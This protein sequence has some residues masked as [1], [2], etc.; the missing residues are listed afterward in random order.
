MTEKVA[1]YN[2]ILQL[3]SL[4]YRTAQTGLECIHL[5]PV[6]SFP[7]PGR[8]RDV[9]KDIRFWNIHQSV[10]KTMVN[11]RVVEQK[12]ETVKI[13]DCIGQKFPEHNWQP[14]REFKTNLVEIIHRWIELYFGKIFI[15]L[16]KVDVAI[17]MLSTSLQLKN[18]TLWAAGL[19]L[20]M[21]CINM[22][23][24]DSC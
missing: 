21:S 10:T 23:R 16:L 11:V 14:I 17:D 24:W 4:N 3:N 22:V 8:P 15:D 5:L 9:Y 20:N 2:N 13:E 7:R 18:A 19:D 12:S 1:K 6:D